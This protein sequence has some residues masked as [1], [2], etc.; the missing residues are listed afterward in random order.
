MV[1]T[2]RAQFE[3]YVSWWRWRPAEARAELRRFL[4]GARADGLTQVEAVAWTP[5]IVVVIATRPGDP[6]GGEVMM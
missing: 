4:A 5:S 1:T 2:A 3:T 6:T